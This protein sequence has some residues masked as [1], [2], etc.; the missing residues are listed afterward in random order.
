MAVW[1][2]ENDQAC[3]GGVGGPWGLRVVESFGNGPGELAGRVG[4]GEA[5]RRQHS[6]LRFAHGCEGLHG[7]KGGRPAGGSVGCGEGVSV[8]R[9]GG[10]PVCAA[11][12][13]APSS[14]PAKM[15]T[16]MITA[17]VVTTLR[18]M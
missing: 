14:P 2:S 17:S 3:G 13:C 16:I 15:A 8:G 18:G 6:L 11:A 12:L 4:G 5:Q 1:Y 9:D 7:T 10:V